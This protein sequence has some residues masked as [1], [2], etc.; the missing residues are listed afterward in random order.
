M[1]VKF[2]AIVSIA[3][4]SLALA[5]MMVSATLRSRAGGRT[6][7]FAGLCA[8]ALVYSVGYLF[9]LLAPDLAAAL[10]M[11]RFEY[12]GIVAIAPFLTLVA[13]EFLD[14]GAPRVPA[15]LLFVVPAGILAMAWTTHLHGLYYLDPILT[16]AAGLSV[17]VFGRGPAYWVHVLYQNLL[18]AYCVTIFLRN[19]VRGS[20]ARR[21][22]ARFMLAGC[23]LPWGGFV[24]YLAGA[25]PMNL[26][27]TPVTLAFTGIFF[28]VGFFR[29]RMFDLRPIARDTIFEQMRDAVL[30]TD[31]Q[32]TIVDHNTEARRLYPVL[33]SIRGL[34]DPRDLAPDIPSLAEAMVRTDID[35]VVTLGLPEG[36]R[37]FNLHHS[38]LSD[39]SGRRLGTAHVLTDITE[40]LI[41]EDRLTVQ[42]TTDELTGAANRRHFFDRARVE[43]ERAQRYGRP[44]GVAILDMDDFKSINDDF[45][46]PAG[47]DALRIASRLCAE[48]LR[49]TDIMGR[50]GGDEFAFAFP[51]CD[52]AQAR[53]AAERLSRILASAAFPYGD[54]VIRLSASV[55]YAGSSSG[56]LPDLDS[57][58]KLADERMY[59]KKGRPPSF[60]SVARDPDRD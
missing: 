53:E 41:L 58:L 60:R 18:I 8:S 29:Y 39:R 9:E 7:S 40:R 13:Y 59:E 27:P 35:S 56:P 3:A 45:G 44:F 55:G 21:V 5:V 42:A 36:E 1:F 31:D 20:R 25:V 23:V 24:L 46:H 17:L 11:V 52:E 43:L 22:Q 32:G 34:R 6:L 50:Y 51:E 37:S 54:A 2:G 38:A 16:H 33:A 26:D 48:T 28:A 57:L 15:P 4:S 12:L 10:R 19:A 49:S 47:D 30:V 14:E